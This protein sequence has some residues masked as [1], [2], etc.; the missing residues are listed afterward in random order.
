VVQG[1]RDVDR[2]AVLAGS[3]RG[4]TGVR[5]G[6]D[7]GQTGVRP[8]EVTS[9][10]EQAVQ[11]PHANSRLTRVRLATSLSILALWYCAWLISQL[12]F[13]PLPDGTI[14]QITSGRTFEGIPS[15]SPDGT[16]IAFR[17]DPLGNGDICVSAADGRDVT[18]LTAASV[19]DES[20]PA[21][22][23]DGS[24]IAFRSAK[25][26][27]SLV[28][29]AGGPIRPLTPAGVNPAWTPDGKAIIYSLESA[30]GADSRQGVSEGWKVD[31]ETAAKRMLHRADFHEPSISP[32]GIRIAYWGRPLDAFNRRRYGSSR[33][34]IWTIPIRGGSRV[35]VT[36]DVAA[37]S[38]PIW[39]ADGRF[40]Y[41]ISSR[42]G[43]SAL[44]RVRI[45]ERSGRVKGKPEIVP[46]PSSE[47]VHVTRSADGRRFAWSDAKPLERVM[48][49]RFDA[50]ARTTRG[51]PVEIMPN[52]PEWEGPDPPI[53]LKLDPSANRVSRATAPG[54]AF[55]GHWSPDGRLFAGTAAGAVWIYSAE[56]RGYHQLRLGGNPVWL[57]DG[58][59]LIFA[60]LGKL[61]MGDAVLKISREL[62]AIPDQQLD[63]PRLSPDNQYLYYTH[64]GADANLWVMTLR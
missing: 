2:F 33:V 43:Y 54:G 24:T 9:L 46:T 25:A 7:R 19:D 10:S 50:D 36:D 3:D 59:R 53:E 26:G 62:L 8:V 61:F 57:Q 55:P 13:D 44:W 18:N 45:D 31:V 41:Y 34:D 21:F 30:A 23:P 11:S 49:I 6:S 39:S 20:D 37:E 64:I 56:T 16:R 60:S 47:P 38:S 5:P 48:R 28:P 17:C 51:S 63:L 12:W 35:Q 4:Q 58:R 29:V 32:N 40:L 14:T 15:L 1:R 27:I 52:D 42:I 22:S